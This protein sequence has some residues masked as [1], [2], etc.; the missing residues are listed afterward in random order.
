MGYVKKPVLYRMGN[1][2]ASINYGRRPIAPPFSQTF[3]E[4]PGT[5]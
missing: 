2:L 5:S 3:R 1:R 4:F